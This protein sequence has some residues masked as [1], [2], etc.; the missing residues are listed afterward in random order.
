MDQFCRMLSLS[1]RLTRFVVVLL[2]VAALGSVLGAE[3]KTVEVPQ[4]WE[5]KRVY[6]TGDQYAWYRCSVK[7]P[8]AWSGRGLELFLEPVDDAKEVYWNDVRVARVGAMPPAYRSGLG[9]KE[10]HSIPSEHIRPGQVNLLAIRVYHHNSRRGFSVAAPVL[11]GEGEAIRLR[12]EWSARSGDNLEWAKEAIAGATVFSAVEKSEKLEQEL[13]TFVGGAGASTPAESLARLRPE[14]DL[15]VELV[16]SDPAIGQPLSMKFDER[17]RMWLVQY[18]QYPD[19]AGLT[20]VSRDMHLRSVY[21]KVPLAPPNHVRGRDKVTIHE[22]T[23][24]DGSFDRHK[25]FVE[26]LSLVTSVALGRGGVYV[27]N[28][29]YL[30][31]YPDRDRDDVPDGDPEV[32]LEG[33]GIEDSHSIANSMR[34]GP[35]GWLYGAQGS[36]VSGKIRRPGSDAEPVHTLGQLIWRYHPET[37]RYE[38]FAEGGGNA[39]GV[40]IDSRGRVFSGHNGGNTRGFHYVQGG[41]Y[42]KG[43]GKHGE[44]S[45]PYAL[46]YFQ[47]MAHHDVRRFTHTFVIYEDAA[48]P[49]RYQGNLF[50]VEPLQGRVVFSEVKRDRSSFKTRDLGYALQSEDPWFRPVDIQVGPGGALYVADLY[51][52]RIDHSSHYQGRIHRASGR[53][54]RL[55]GKDQPPVPFGKDLGSFSE[56]RLAKVLRDGTRWERQTALRLLADRSRLKPAK[57]FQGKV[58]DVTELW[59]AYHGAGGRVDPVNLSHGDPQVRA[60]TVRLL[61]DERNVSNETAQLLAELARDETNVHVRSQLASSAR[62]LP[63]DGARSLLRNMFSRAEDANDIHIPLLLWWAIEAKVES[64][65]DDIVKLASTASVRGSGL[66][67]RHIASRLMRR[68]AAGGKRSQLMACVELLR[69]ASEGERKE[70]LKG[71]E[72]AFKGRSMA[73]LPEELTAALAEA[74]GVSV[75]LKARQGDA[76]ALEET[77]KVVRDESADPLGRIQSINLLGELVYPPAVPVLL[78]VV[79]RSRDDSARREA[80]ASLSSYPDETIGTAVVAL[81]GALPAEVREAAQVMLSS[82]RTWTLQFLAAMGTADLDARSVSP[83]IVR[84]FLLHDSPRIHELVKRHWDL[85]GGVPDDQQMARLKQIKQL[86]GQGSGNPYKGKEQYRVLCGVCHK[87]YG[88]G[89]QIGPDLTPYQ[90]SDLDRLLMNII[91]PTTEIREGYENYVVTTKDGRTLNG[92]LVDRDQGLILLRGLDGRNT[93]VTPE[94]I[95]SM[96]ASPASLMPEGLLGALS[97]QQIRD[98]LAYLRSSQ[99]LP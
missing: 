3:W 25:T 42:Q 41:Y 75:A 71:L 95:A 23:N 87:L 4:A 70:L 46:G 53:I 72:L 6:Q 1:S 66:Y 32:L 57:R 61:G 98:L 99:P 12:G 35:D 14:K 34:W 65:R 79:K 26:G 86:T 55:R 51:E 91:S 36:T 62:R 78:D 47:A 60:W 48:L 37:R 29:P 2:H 15:V 83:A 44:L 5:D 58:R 30:L 59:A 11:F 84:K 39:F 13:K 90:R 94:A 38:V 49:E 85:P 20:M 19:P 63:M 88:E 64:H 67:Q 82:R 54:Y 9:G 89:G 24:G 16:L 45:N 74:G 43:F 10:R 17:G 93:A 73:G 22:D 52:Q 50:G 21:D 28:P 96:K 76:Q 80:L 56:A 69:G 92:F 8:Q 68:L 97:D 27:L 18:L 31:F 77:L 7:V 33:F 81:H 40:E